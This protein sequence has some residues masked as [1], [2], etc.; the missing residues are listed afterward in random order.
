MNFT[1]SR[2]C[3]FEPQRIYVLAFS[4][5]EPGTRV[6]RWT[7]QWANYYVP[8]VA[9]GVVAVRGDR[10]AIA[11]MGVDGSIHFAGPEGF[12]AEHVDRSSEGPIHR[13]VLRDIRLIGQTIFVA[14]LGR[15][16]YRRQASGSWER[17]DHGVVEPLG[18]E[19]IGGFESIDGFGEAEIY[20]VG[21]A[22]DMFWCKDGRWSRISSMTNLILTKVLCG[23][24]GVVYI[25]GQGG[26]LLRGR[27]DSWSQVE[28][29]LTADTFWDLAW[30]DGSLW[31]STTDAL[32]RLDAQGNPE[33]VSVNG[34]AP[35]FRYLSA[36]ELVLVA[37]G[38]RQLLKL[39]DGAWQQLPPP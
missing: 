28:H 4:K 34:A 5:L 11:V 14:G 10:P 33:R 16:I 6:F 18:S 26:F 37:A 8:F 19:D 30:H 36:A 3:V 21:M 38:G 22:G 1:I 13:G 12:A 39:Q 29:G 31:L 32:Y 15:Q 7:D 35:D 20:A 2:P 23:P 25:A 24:D 27:G 17:F 9:G